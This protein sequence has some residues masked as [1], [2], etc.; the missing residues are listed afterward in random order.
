MI[1]H[2]LWILRG[3]HYEGTITPSVEKGSD[4]MPV[5][6][7]V[8]LGDEPFANL[9]C[10]PKGWSEREGADTPKGLISAIGDYIMDY[11]E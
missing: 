10:G 4:G 7:R 3:E 6:F 11:Y 1:F 5:Y 8:T 9:C 2:C